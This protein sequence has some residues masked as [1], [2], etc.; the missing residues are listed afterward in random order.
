MF[1]KK[2]KTSITLD[3]NVYVLIKEYAKRIHKPV[4]Y[5]VNNLLAQFILANKVSLQNKKVVYK[6]GV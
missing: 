4:S 6:K 5:V 3:E 1:G 2:T